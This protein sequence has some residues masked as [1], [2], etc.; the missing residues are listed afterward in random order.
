MSCNTFGYRWASATALV[1]A[2]SFDDPRRVLTAVRFA[3]LS[4]RKIVLAHVSGAPSSGMHEGG[5]RRRRIVRREMPPRAASGDAELPKVWSE[6]LDKVFL[7]GDVPSE[8]VPDIARGMEADHLLFCSQHAAEAFWKTTDR[9][10]TA[11]IC[12]APMWVMGRNISLG[13]REGIQQVLLPLS[14]RN[15]FEGRLRDATQLANAM[16]ATLVILHV[17]S[18]EENAFEESCAGWALSARLRDC[19]DRVLGGPRRIQISVCDGDPAEAILKFESEHPHSLVLMRGPGA[20][21]FEQPGRGVTRRVLREAG[22][23]MVLTRADLPAGPAWM[24]PNI[25]EALSG[26]RAIAREPGGVQ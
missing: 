16:A 19:L 21:A 24:S 7:L 13:A 3:S 5:G 8:D 6:I 9:Y 17:Q 15:D 26:S 11:A 10:D 20:Y 14:F 4:N 12:D 2:H 23:P 1:I 25:H 22:C 18:H